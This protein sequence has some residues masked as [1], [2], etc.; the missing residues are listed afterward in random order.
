MAIDETGGLHG[1]RD[2]HAILSLEKTPKQKVFGK[3]L[4]AGLKNTPVNCE[5]L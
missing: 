2:Y 1:M 3:V 4:P 5:T